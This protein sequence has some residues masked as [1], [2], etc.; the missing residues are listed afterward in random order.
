MHT[1]LFQELKVFNQLELPSGTLLFHGCRE[2][3]PHT[4]PQ[5][6]LLDGSR[7]WLSQSAVYASS[8]AFVDSADLGARLLWVCELAENVPSLQ[9]S[10]ASLVSKSPWGSSFPWDFPNAFVDYANAVL[11][12]TGARALLDHR[13]GDIYKEILLTMPAQALRVVRIIELPADKAVA[14]ALAQ[15]C[16]NC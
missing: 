10:Q 11:P 8:Y 15:K 5:A 7:K 16:F 14:E 12:G 6:Q 13:K 2:K 4:N 3:S 1:P 9:G